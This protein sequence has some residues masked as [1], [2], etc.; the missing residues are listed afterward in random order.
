MFA[1]SSSGRYILRISPLGVGLSVPKLNPASLVLFGVLALATTLRL[2]GLGRESLWGDEILSVLASRGPWLDIVAERTTFNQP[3]YFL[4]LHAWMGF[5]GESEFALRFPSAILGVA[6]VFFTFI[7]TRHLLG[8]RIALGVAFLVAVSPVMIWYSQETRFYALTTLLLVVSTYLM[9]RYLETGRGFFVIAYAVAAFLGLYTHYYFLPFVAA[10]TLVALIWLLRAQ[11]RAD[12][13]KWLT[14][15]LIV[16]LALISKISTVFSDVSQAAGGA[17]TLP[18]SKA[19][20]HFIYAI[21]LTDQGLTGPLP[22]GPLPVVITVWVLTGMGVAVATWRREKVIVLT[23]ICLAALAQFV[24]GGLF[25][26]LPV[27]LRYLSPMTPLWAIMTCYG[28]AW[29]TTQAFPWALRALPSQP[30]VMR[31]LVG[32][33]VAAL[34]GWTLILWGQQLTTPTKGNWREVAGLIEANAQPSDLVFVD[35][36]RHFKHLK[37]YLEDPPPVWK[38]GKANTCNDNQRVWLVADPSLLSAA[39]NELQQWCPET[40]STK[41]TGFSDVLL[42]ESR[43]S[44]ALANNPEI[45]CDGM[46]PNILG[47]SADDRIVGSDGDDIIHGLGGNDR[48]IGKSGNDVICGGQGNDTLSGESGDDKLIGNEAD[49]TLYSGSGTNLLDGGSEVDRCYG[50]GGNRILECEFQ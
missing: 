35:P 46:V 13:L 5:F 41:M 9:I 12:L 6:T 43:S 20:T 30:A 48:I 3:F 28:F 32:V 29:L 31:G 34:L 36:P 25:F 22:G 17:F 19:L 27:L 33:G 7:L 16:S 10:H 38:K 37:F 4:I 23:V 47:S 40:F 24:V 21:G 45:L 50:E 26:D 42:V 39:A 18:L 1:D 11:R 49:D 14:A 44:T 2:V 8:V 15:Q